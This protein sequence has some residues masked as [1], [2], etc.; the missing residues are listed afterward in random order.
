MGRAEKNKSNRNRSDTL[1]MW[2]RYQ[3]DAIMWR[4]V[5]LLQIPTTL[6]TVIFAITLWMTRSVV[7]N[8]PPKPAPGTYAMNEI[9]DSEFVTEATEFVNLIASYQ[10]LNA[11]R[12][13]NEA[14]TRTVEPFLNLF[15]NKVVPNELSTIEATS[16]SQFFFVDPTK[17]KI[18]Y[19]DDHVSVTLFGERVKVVAGQELPGL[20]SQ[21]TVSMR[22][23][24]RHKLNQYGIAVV[25]VEFN[26]IK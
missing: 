5:A 2:E 12:Q 15:V 26:D 17:T 9:P 16:R 3:D 18:T 24:P 1:R 20:N 23:V 4:A 21:Y 10:P 22:I 19:H 11:R 7:V 13:F 25:G 14:A 8:I 6:I